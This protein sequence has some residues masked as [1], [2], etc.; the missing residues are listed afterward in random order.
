MESLV[1]EPV[2]FVAKTVD[3]SLVDDPRSYVLL[4]PGKAEPVTDR[5]PFIASLSENNVVPIPTL[6]PLS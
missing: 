2:R 3:Q 6:V 1:K 5:E 4:V